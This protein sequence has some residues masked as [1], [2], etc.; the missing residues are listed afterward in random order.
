MS[1]LTSTFGLDLSLIII[2]MVN[3]AIV[4]V[5]LW[6]FLYK[7]SIKL[8]DERRAKI[9]QG[10]EDASKAETRLQEIEGE[11]TDII[12]TA[13]T[14]ANT[15]LGNAKQRARE[16]SEALLAHTQERSD[17]QL[18]ATAAQAE[19]MKAQ[20]LRESREEIGKAAV[21]AAAKVLKET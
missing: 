18:A 6:W 5:G 9:A 12:A 8:I 7:P 1:E 20:A 17:A 14:E 21:L 19:E 11:R 16:Q 10:V 13:T 15:I 2:Q 4:L 3:F